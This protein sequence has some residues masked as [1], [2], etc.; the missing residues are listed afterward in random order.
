LGAAPDL[1]DPGMRF[2]RRHPL[3]PC[4][5][6]ILCGAVLLGAPA[7]ADA[8]APAWKLTVASAPT[9]FAPG[10]TGLGGSSYPQYN[11]FA[12]N[13]G[14]APTSGPITLTD[15]LPEGIGPGEAVLKGEDD[16]G[17]RISI[18][19]QS[20]GRLVTCT[21]PYPLAPGR[22]LQVTIPVAVAA[23]AGPSVTNLASVTGGG[24]GGASAGTVTAIGSGPAP[25]GF[26][27]GSAGLSAVA[28]G[29][30]GAAATQASSH[31]PRLTIDAGLASALANSALVG[32][33]NARRLRLTL[34]RGLIVNPGATPARCSESQLG[35]LGG[36][37]GCPPESQVG[38]VTLQTVQTAPVEIDT[39]PLYNMIPPPGAAAELAFNAIGVGIFVHLL[40]GL[41]AAGNYEFAAAAD[42]LPA[43][44]P[45]LGLQ[46]QLWGDPP[47][48]T[49]PF[50]TMP[51]SCRPSL[52]ANASVTSWEDPQEVSRAA[53]LE[54][55]ADGTPVPTTGCNAPEFE[56]TI[57]AKPTTN[58]ADSPTGLDFALHLPQ[59]ESFESLAEATLK[60]ASVTLPQGMALN[61]S[62]ANGLAACS[63]AQFGLAS[64]PGQLP[65][66]TDANPAACP[67]AAKVGNLEVKTQLLDHPMSGSIYV[68]EPY[69]NPFG[70]LLAIYLAI[71]DPQS[72]VVI[73]LAGK[74]SPDP[75]TGRLTATFADAPELPFEDFEL[76]FF[77]GP[78]AALKS[79]TTCGTYAIATTM[80]PWSTPEGADAALA[81][82]F[83]VASPGSSTSVG[84]PSCPGGEAGA[85]HAP[86]FTAGTLAPKAGAS[87]PLVLNLARADG[88]QRLAAVEAT[89]PPGLAGGLAGV[90]R[91]SGAAL[92]V[93]EARSR[94]GGAALEQASPACADDSA[95]GTVDLSAGAGDAPFQLRGRV[96]LG[97][98]SESAPLSLAIVVPA[99]AGPF[100]LGAVLVRVA[101]HVDPT[102]G[103]IHAVS[104]SLPSVLQ[105]VPLDLRRIVLRLDRPGLI[106]NPTS[107]A[108]MSV[109]AGATSTAGQTARLSSRFQ[110]GGCGRLAFRPKLGLRLVGPTH[111]GAHPQLRAVLAT[112]KGDAN[113]SRA[114]ITLPGSELLDSRHIGAVCTR[115]RY[116]ARTCPKS[117]VQGQAKVWT[118]LLDRPLTGPI[119]LRASDHEL[120]DLVASLDGEVHLDLGARVDS[121][122]GRIRVA[123]G[124]VPDL[125]FAKVVLALRGGAR[126]LLVNAGGVCSGALRAAAG[127][128][129][130]SGKL[131]VAHPAVKA[132]CPSR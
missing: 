95:I 108:P 80:R 92:A 103:R 1:Y 33:G 11:L 4:L 27:A 98:P 124:R 6:A 57:E 71:D 52:T 19:C 26:V 78:R 3:G 94:P 44:A 39:Q 10:S 74:V 89:L 64:A 61:P 58:L 29:P 120:P 110:V 48:S 115:E 118:P 62:G 59:E 13:V 17:E 88:S 43:T 116:A 68:A 93:L 7:S 96:Y 117:S 60:D 83:Q 91:C 104:S 54:D 100:D 106:L 24:G 55:P 70:S 126:G 114:A 34:P 73:K 105:G 84:V 16:Q 2:A 127:L 121:A 67:E 77:G 23:S 53:E 123:F 14:A 79:P 22:S 101:L 63:P 25:F 49:A 28:N 76:H 31:P 51:S 56:P 50:L 37:G 112:R 122:R 97:G 87:S 5:G 69:Q 125:R 129:A 119:Y 99:A 47:G 42:E 30:D 8:A 75:Q 46:V 65:L 36:G 40:G 90:A 82:S 111:R 38:T 12:T 130:H 15:P 113:I 21:D 41:D 109:A 85:P 102:T 32:A 18:P 20:A 66:R 35:A 128:R 86:S 81:N 131:R 45:F 107:C 72:G 9:A 132:D